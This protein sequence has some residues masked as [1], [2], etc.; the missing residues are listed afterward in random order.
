M[1]SLQDYLGIH[2]VERSQINT[3]LHMFSAASVP[4]Y[5]NKL[6]VGP[7]DCIPQGCIYRINFRVST[8]RRP[9]VRG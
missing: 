3:Y 6:A 7:S 8:M 2:M 4:R 5:F 1:H 9:N